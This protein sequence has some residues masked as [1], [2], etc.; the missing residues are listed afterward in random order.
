MQARLAFAVAAH[1][2]A[3]I[4]V[5][6][7]ILSVGDAVFAQ[8]CARFIRQFR[9]RGTLLF[10]SHDLSAALTLCERAIWLDHGSVQLMGPTREVIYNYSAWSMK[11]GAA[12]PS[13]YKIEH[14]PIP[15]KDIRADAHPESFVTEADIFDFDE[16]VPAQGEG[17]ARVISVNFADGISG[18]QIQSVR[19]GDNVA[20]HVTAEAHE[21]ISHPVI[22]FFVRDRL[23]QIL[24]GD[25]TF[26]ALADRTK[27]VDAGSNLRARF[28]FLMPYLPTGDYSITAAIADE[29]P[30]VGRMLHWLEGALS[31]KVVN[32]HIAQGLVGIAMSAIDMDVE[33]KSS[34]STGTNYS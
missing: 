11:S 7:E 21:A 6:D 30:P 20:L 23:G 29:P 12:D 16:N 22:G 28:T 24:F 33:P 32:S 8:R 25:N 4:L 34:G 26:I 5:V 10:V 13:A 2:D 15:G 3:E 31:F 27:Q 9:K 19:G 14:A 1:V 17:G 18:A